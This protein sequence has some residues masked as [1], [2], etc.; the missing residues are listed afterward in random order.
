MRKIVYEG[1]SFGEWNPREEEIQLPRHPYYK[2]KSPI[3]FAHELGH[4]ELGHSIGGSSLVGIIEERDAWRYALSKLPPE[5]IDLDFIDFIWD[6]NI[7][8]LH[9]KEEINLARK[10]KSESMEL[11]RKKLGGLTK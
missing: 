10:A 4:A 2:S 6:E 11:A 1:S 8:Q 3:V 9:N 5:E 7:Y